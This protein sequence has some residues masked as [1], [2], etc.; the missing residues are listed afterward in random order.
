MEE[1][2]R[3][4]TEAKSS[5]SNSNNDRAIELY[6][7]F[8]KQV[9]SAPNPNLLGEKLALAYNNRGFLK[10]RRV[11]FEGAILDYTKSVNVNPKSC[12]TFYNRG[13]VLYRLS[14]FD[15]AISDMKMALNLDPSFEPAQTGLH[16]AEQD[17]ENKIKRGW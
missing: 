13:T 6:T 1:A 5:E 3:I 7:E 17:R 4:F 9:E 14:K 11:D 8:I 15:E 16:F 12:I 2:E 10:Y